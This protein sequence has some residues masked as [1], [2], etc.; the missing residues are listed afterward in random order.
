MHV[1]LA[2]SSYPSGSGLMC[3]FFCAGNI[4]IGQFIATSAEVTFSWWFSKGVLP[5]E[6]ALLQVKDV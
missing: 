1:F 3:F 4:S 5:R 2:V 6:K